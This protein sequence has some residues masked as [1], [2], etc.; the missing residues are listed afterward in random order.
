[1]GDIKGFM[2]YE[3]ELPKYRQVEERLEDWK[4]VYEPFS[5]NKLR[6]QA[7]RCM[8]CGILF[9]TTAARLGI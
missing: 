2:K 8:D 6:L 9:A 3:R 4:E 7:S 1:M 5:E